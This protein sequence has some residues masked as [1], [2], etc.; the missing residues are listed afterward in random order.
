MT[1]VGFKTA[2]Q[3]VLQALDASIAGKSVVF[4]EQRHDQRDKNLLQSGDV[5]LQEVRDVL[6]RANGTEHD[7]SSHHN[8]SSITVHVVKRSEY[9]VFWYIKW[10]MLEPNLW[11]ISV[12]H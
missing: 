11:F 12:H 2:K 9:G 5:S 3:S 1:R 4:H 7:E 10:Y 8:V 6:G